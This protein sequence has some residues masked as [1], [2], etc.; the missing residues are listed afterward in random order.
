M[1]KSN[2]LRRENLP[3]LIKIHPSVIWIKTAV[4]VSILLINIHRANMT[5]DEVE[6]TLQFEIAADSSP[7]KINPEGPL[8]FLRGYI[9]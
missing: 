8:N 6:T 1:A 7:V 2:T 9:Y 3:Y 5:L 4:L